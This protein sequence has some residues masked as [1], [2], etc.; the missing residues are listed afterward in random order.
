MEIAGAFGA[1]VYTE[2]SRGFRVVDSTGG[3]DRVRLFVN[4]VGKVG[5]GTTTPLSNSSNS[6]LHIKGNSN[7]NEAE[8]RIGCPDNGTGGVI[9]TAIQPA[10]G[11]LR[12]RLLLSANLMYD[13]ASGWHS[14]VSGCGGAGI[15]ILADETGWGTEVVL[16]ASVADN[17]YC[18]I[19]NA[20]PTCTLSCKLMK[21]CGS[22]ETPV[23]CSPNLG[24]GN[25]TVSGT[26][27]IGLGYGVTASGTSAS[28][29]GFGVIASGT[30]SVAMVWGAKATGNYS[31]AIGSS[32]GCGPCATLAESVAMGYKAISASKAGLA[33]GIYTVT[34][35]G[36]CATAVG[37]YSQATADFSSAFG[38]NSCATGSNSLAVGWTSK[39]LATSSI[40]IGYDSCA[41]TSATYSVAVGYCARI[42]N[43]DTTAVGV[44]S[45]ATATGA[46]AFGRSSYATGSYSSAVGYYALANAQNASAFGHKSCATTSAIGVGYYATASG[47]SSTAV[48]RNATAS[49]TE[50]TGV[51]RAIIASGHCSTAVGYYSCLLYTSPSPRDRG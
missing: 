11:Q 41:A 42:T 46:S 14:A 38:H 2:N 3:T 47:A 23:V 19:F 44:A 36:C 32:Y 13:C 28:G 22:L 21:V 43:T 48:G 1:G 17:Q 8:L 50:T 37:S 5:I 34:G 15:S 6:G 20:C 33:L 24:Y 29:V 12:P 35:A 4:D 16:L 45:C 40:V 49:G 51:G 39:A 7:G 18:A 10:V 30:N 26:N 31:T 27:A 25:N 9:Q